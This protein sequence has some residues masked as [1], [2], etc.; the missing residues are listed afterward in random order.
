D[1]VEILT[2]NDDTARTAA[3]QSGQVHMINRVDPK[4]VALLA[5]NTDVAIEQVGGPGH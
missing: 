5:G 3:I 2:I 4:I 1:G